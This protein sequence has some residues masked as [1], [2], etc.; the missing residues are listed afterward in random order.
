MTHRCATC[1]VEEQ[2]HEELARLK[3]EAET[4]RQQE[5]TAKCAREAAED[6]ALHAQPWWPAL[7]RH[8]ERR[9]EETGTTA[10]QEIEEWVGEGFER[11]P[12]DGY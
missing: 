9:L 8:I 5:W 6:T 12:Y 11:A 3:A 2:E 4:A 10:R 7:E 1:I